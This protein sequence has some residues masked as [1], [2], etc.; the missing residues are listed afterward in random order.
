MQTRCCASPA[1]SASVAQLADIDGFQREVGH[2]E[3][4]VRHRVAV[5][6]AARMHIREAQQPAGG[7]VF[8]KRCWHGVLRASC[9]I[10]LDPAAPCGPHACTFVSDQQLW[11]Y[12]AR[13]EA[14]KGSTYNLQ[15]LHGAHS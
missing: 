9:G 14:I 11:T 5:D 1:L 3:H 10:N 6:A 13:A 4:L 2:D 7:G 15:I 8:N 12:L